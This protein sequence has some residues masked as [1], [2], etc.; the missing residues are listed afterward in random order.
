MQQFVHSLVS[1]F[2]KYLKNIEIHF[3]SWKHHLDSGRH[4]LPQKLKTREWNAHCVTSTTFIL[5]SKNILTLKHSLLFSKLTMTFINICKCTTKKYL[6]KL[7][8]TTRCCM[9]KMCCMEW[10]SFPFYKRLKWVPTQ[11]IYWSQMG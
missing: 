8:I 2:L 3:F 11:I 4:C 9:E 1:N 5:M 7:H 6:K 10:S